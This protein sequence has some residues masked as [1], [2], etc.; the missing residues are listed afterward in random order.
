MWINRQDVLYSLRS[1]RRAPLLS[2]VAIAALTLGIGLNAGVFTLLNALFLTSPTRKD[3]ASF[4]QIY[5]RYEGWF[6]GAG[7][8]SRFTTEDYEAIHRESRVLDDTAAWQ[9]SST[10]LEQEQRRLSTLLVTCN[11]FHVFGVDRPLAGRFLTEGECKRGSTAQVVV[12]SETFWRTLFGADPHV[13]GRTIHLNGLPFEVIGIVSAHDANSFAAGMF[14]PYTLQPLLD[15]SNNRLESADSPWLSIAGRMRGGYSQ[16]DAKAELE[17]IMRQQDRVYVE[18]KVSPFN[19]RTSI[20]LTN[21]SVIED[22][23]VRDVAVIL[24]GL[25]L[26]PLSL[27]LLLACTNVTMMFLSRAVVRRGEIAIRLALGVGRARLARM[28]LLESLL[29]TLLAGGTSM[30]LANRVPLLIIDM[31]DPNEAEFVPLMHPDWR[32]FGYLAALVLV[33][34]VVSSFAPMRA[35]WKLDL[36]TAL[37]GREAGATGRSRTTSGLIIAQVAMSFVLLAAAVLFARLPRLVTKMDPGIE[38]KQVMVVGLNVDTSESNHARAANIYGALEAR[39]R[40]IPNVQSIAYATLPPFRQAPP[41]EVRLPG[42]MKGQGRPAAVDVVTKEF[43]PTFGIRL[44][45]GRVFG[46]SDGN[47]KAADPVAVVSQAFARQFWPAV[48]PLGKVVVTPDERR[49]TIVGVVADTQAERFGVTDG[50]RLYTLRDPASLAGALYVRFKGN[51]KTA[52]NA[53]RN[54]VRAIDPTQMDMPQTIW[55]TLEETAQALRTLARIIVVMAGIAVL[56]AITGVY[57]V[58]SFAVNQRTREF[59]VKMVLGANRKTIFKSV[60]SRGARQI[61]IGLIAGVALAEPAA[62]AFSRLLKRS[63]LPMQSFDWMVFGIS[64]LLITAISVAAMFMPALRATQVDPIKA[65]RTE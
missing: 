62:L 64:A 34:S 12:L 16:A 44:V 31:V 17:T 10:V 14:V 2:L 4:K 1:A 40:A 27:V 39:I 33:A 55:E 52:E 45:D 20:I 26:G 11:Y 47:A 50:P 48:N 24:L 43:F 19:R 13:V 22:P 36:L 6:S 30:L 29:T 53:V 8:F 21:G 57:G 60:M 25:I 37:R 46:S 38:T 49:L 7:Q 63:P 9:I 41:S 51:S 23:K 58:L 61:A 56:L 35:A 18:R 28:L 15:G 3:P 65:L 5:P 59:G 32:V 54:A 42:Q